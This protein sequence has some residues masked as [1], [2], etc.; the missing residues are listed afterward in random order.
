MRAV[1]LLVLFLTPSALAHPQDGPHADVEIEITD[2]AVVFDILIN[3]VMID[4][5]GQFPRENPANIHPIEEDAIRVA[6]HAYIA[7]EHRVAIDGVEVAP[8]V[9]TFKVVRSDPSHVA[10]FPRTGMRGLT[11]IHLILEYPIKGALK[12]VAMR[13]GAFPPDYTLEP[14]E[15][16]E[17]PP[18]RLEARLRAEGKLSIVTFTKEEPEFIFHATGLSAEERFASVPELSE[19]EPVSREVTIPAVT[20]AIVSAYAVIGLVTLARAKGRAA[21][22]AV[23]V[24][25]P[26]VGLGAF[27]L[28]DVGRVKVST[29]IEEPESLSETEALAIFEPLHANIY[30][31]FDYQSEGEIY[32]AL[33][34]SVTGE[35]LDRLYNQVFGSLIMHEEGG[36]VSS[37]Q[38]VRL[39]EAT[40][41]SVG[42]LD[43]GPHADKLGFTVQARWQVDGVVNHFGHSH[44]RTNEYLARFAVVEGEAGWR[45]ASSEVLE[46]QRLDTDPFT[47]P[48]Q[49]TARPV[50]EL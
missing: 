34:R 49:D 13:W 29:V 47:D 7:R 22:L 9:R 17:R 18:I 35:M 4:E 15:T 33:A 32:D 8:I 21:R 28:R 37:V 30:R 45:I 50:G 2:E 16:G 31:A 11:K 27:A 40:I 23:G 36:A 48:T 1:A 3:L 25:L 41:E 42:E 38:A 20:I 6:L 5:M 46:Q 44:W 24:A 19:R 39:G 10:L 26:V 14:D 43:A 12:S